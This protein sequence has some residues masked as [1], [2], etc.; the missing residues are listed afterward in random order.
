MG[1]N[2][3]NLK[4]KS[5]DYGYYEKAELV[6]AERGAV[7]LFQIPDTALLILILIALRH[8]IDLPA[9]IMWGLIVVWVVK[10]IILF[11]FVWRAYDS[12]APKGVYSLIGRRGVAEE[13]LAPTGYVRVSNELWKVEVIGGR[14]I[15]KGETVRIRGIRGLILLVEHV[16]DG[17]LSD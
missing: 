5:R 11:P 17:N 6:E 8:W 9:W 3:D 4:T 14:V 12:M 10:D 1:L 16:D 2:I 15:E 7:S 13:Q